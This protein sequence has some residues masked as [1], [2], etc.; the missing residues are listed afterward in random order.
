MERVKKR[1]F[2]LYPVIVSLLA[3]TPVEKLK[4]SFSDEI[5][6]LRTSIVI[7]ILML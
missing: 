1:K 4:N 2:K 7:F 6:I 3:G 5:T